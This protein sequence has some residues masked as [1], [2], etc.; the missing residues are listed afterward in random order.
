MIATV[1]VGSDSCIM[2]ISVP[3]II[4]NYTHGSLKLL[5]E[6]QSGAE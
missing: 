3:M 4:F 5:K 6:A 2:Q 1:T